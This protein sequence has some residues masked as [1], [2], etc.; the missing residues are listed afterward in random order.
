M[1][2]FVGLQYIRPAC[3]RC[4]CEQ[5]VV[6]T[7]MS[8]KPGP[9]ELERAKADAKRAEARAALD[10]Q[11]RCHADRGLREVRQR[12]ASVLQKRAPGA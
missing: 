3:A 6:G 2:R 10:A 9:E 1:S 7:H 12:L 11:R 8:A 4:V 5:H